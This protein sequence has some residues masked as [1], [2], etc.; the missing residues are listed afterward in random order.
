VSPGR[1]HCPTPAAPAVGTGR[2][3]DLAHGPELEQGQRPCWHSEGLAWAMGSAP[4]GRPG[5]PSR[6]GVTPCHPCQPCP[7]LPQAPLA[8][9]GLGFPAGTR[10]GKSHPPAY[11]ARN[12]APYFSPC[13]TL[14]RPWPLRCRCGR[15]FGAPSTRTRRAAGSDAAR[16]AWQPP[17]L[18]GRESCTREAPCR[19][20]QA[21]THPTVPQPR[22]GC[23]SGSLPAPQGTQGQ[24]PRQG[25]MWTPRSRPT[26]QCP[27][28]PIPNVA[29]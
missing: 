10:L 29:Q 26:A 12:G 2:G 27:K 3:Q 17:R 25:L 14:S 18:A 15:G 13:R 28:S 6:P 4:T 9:P 16:G 20:S 22:P 8:S 19:G 7:G 11:A 23:S 1:G 24:G 21:Q 5:A